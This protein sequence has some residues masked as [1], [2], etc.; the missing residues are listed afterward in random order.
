MNTFQRQCLTGAGLEHW[1]SQAPYDRTLCR[2]TVLAQRERATRTSPARSA[3]GGDREEEEE[4]EREEEEEEE[5]EEG[6]HPTPRR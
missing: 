5:E 1:H 3:S 6:Q 2:H 4:E